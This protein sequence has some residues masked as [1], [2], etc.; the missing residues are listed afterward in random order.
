M[1][2][3]KSNKKKTPE[4]KIKPGGYKT[5][6][7]KSSDYL[8]HVFQTKLNK[9]WLDGTFDTLISK[10]ALEDID[11]YVGNKSGKHSKKDDVFFNT[12]RDNVQLE[13]GIVSDSRI[14]FDDVAQAINLYFDEYNYSKAYSTQSYVYNPPI[15]KDKFLNYSSYYWVPNLPVYESDNTNNTAT[16]NTDVITDINGK[17]THTFVD[18]N[19]TFELQDGMRIQLDAGYG[20]LN[21]KIYLVTGV[22]RAIN[23]RLYT[24]Y[25]SVLRDG[26]TYNQYYP[27]WTDESKYSNHTQGYWDAIDPIRWTYRLNGNPDTRSTTNNPLN[28]ITD[29][30]TDLANTAT[31]TA[32]AM[33]FYA[34]NDRKMYMSDGMIIQ[35]DDSWPGLP[36]GEEHKIYW[37]TVNSSGVTLTP[38]I[39]ASISGNTITQTIN[40][41]LTAAQQAK[42]ESYLS[43]SWDNDQVNWDTLYTATSVKDYHVIDR[44][45]KIATA[46][47]RSNFWVH[48]DTIFKIAEI[49][50]RVDGNLFV[51]KENQAKRPIIEFDGGIHMLYHQNDYAQ[52]W[53]GP[54]DFIIGL[55]SIAS[56]LQ[57]G[58]TY[59]AYNTNV[60]YKR[61]ST[62]GSD[63]V[64]RTLN[65]GDTFLCRFALSD[66]QANTDSLRTRF[67]RNDLYTDANQYTQIGQVKKKVNQPPLYILYDET[68]TRLDDSNKYPSS[69]FAGNKIFNYKIGTGTTVDPEVDLVL[70][71]KD[72]GPKADYV[73]ENA[74]YKEKYTHSLVT[75]DGGLVDTDTIKGYY[76]YK[77]YGKTKHGYTASAV[78]CG[79][80][81]SIKHIVKD[82]SQAQTIDIGYNAWRSS[83]EFYVYR[84]GVANSF[85][86][87]EGYNN[88]IINDK[89]RLR[90]ELVVKGGETYEFHDLIGNL[91]FYSDY[92][93]TV[94]TTGITTSGNTTTVVMPSSGVLYY[95]YSASNKG[96]ITILDNDDY[97]YHDLY[98]DGKRIRQNQYTINA[99]SIVVPASLVSTDSII[100]IDYMDSDSNNEATVYSIPD[101]HK[102]NAQN[103]VLEEFTI[104]ETFDHWEDIIYKTP[105]LTGQSFGIN[106]RHAKVKLDNT[107]GTIFMYDDISIMHDYTY[108]NTALDVREAL[109]TQGREFFGFRRRFKNQVLRL[110]KTNTY[111]SV[112]HIVRDAIKA[113]TSTRRG[114]DLHAKSNMVYWNDDRE[115]KQELTS[116]QTVIYVNE[117]V[118]ADYNSMDHCYVYLSEND[119]SNSYYERLLIKDVDYTIKGSTITLATAAT[120]V[121]ANDPA[122]V[123]L[124]FIDRNEKSYIPASMVKLGLEFATPVQIEGNRILFHDGDYHTWDN[125]KELYNPNDIDFDVVSACLY[126]LEKRIWAG[127]VNQDNTRSANTWLPTPFAD[128]WYDKNLLDNYTEQLYVDYAAKEGFKVYNNSGFYNASDSSTW[129]YSTITH[130]G[131]NVP[132]HWVGAYTYIFGTATPHLTPWHM[133]GF[134]LKPS[135]WDTHYSWTDATKRATLIDSLTKGIVTIPTANVVKTDLRFARWNWDWTNRC[136]V[137]TTGILADRHD[138]LGT[139]Q[140]IYAAQD[141]VFGDY[142]PYEYTWRRS[143]LGQSALVDAIVKL[144]PAKAWTEFF[145]PGLYVENGDT[146]TAKL[147]NKYTRKAITPNDIVYDGDAYGKKVSRIKVKNSTTG[148]GSNSILDLYSMDDV[149]RGVIKLDIDSTG[150]IKHA[151]LT[152]GAVGY[153]DIPIWDITNAGTG[154]NLDALVDFEFIMTDNYYDGNGIN[155]AIRN[156]YLRNFKEDT[157]S[158]QFNKV[159][160]NLLQKVGGFTSENLIDFYTESGAKGKYK[161]NVNDY[162]V[163]LYNGPPRTLYNACNI[164]I[165]R[166]SGGYKVNGISSNKQKFYM[167]EPLKKGSNFITIELP[168]TGSVKRYNDYDYSTLSSVEFGSVFAKIQD[169]YEFVRGYHHYLEYNGVETDYDGDTM[170]IDAAVFA[171]GAQLGEEEVLDIGSSVAYVGKEGRVVSFGSLPGGINT[172]LDSDGNVIKDKELVLDRYQQELSVTIEK[173]SAKEIGSITFAEVDFEHIVQFDNTTQFNDTLFNDV[174]NQRHYRLKARGQ[175]TKDWTGNTRA[176]GYLVFENKIV[177]NFD[178]SVQTIADLYSYNVENVNDAYTKAENLTIGNSNKDWITESL[179]DDQ[180]FAK[181]YQGMIKNKGITDSIEPFNRSSML[182]DGTSV[183]SVIEEWMFRHSYYGDTTNVDAP[184]IKLSDDLIDNNIE[185]IDFADS[186]IEFVN[187]SSVTFNTEVLSQYNN[188]SYKLKS[189]GE[190]I[191]ETENDSNIVPTLKDMKVIY[192]STKDYANIETWIGTKSYKRGDLVRHKGY[193]YKCNVNAIGFNT[194]AAQLTFTGTVPS[195]TFTYASASVPNPASATIDGVAVWFDEQDTVFNNIVATGNVTAPSVPSG[196]TLTVDG[197]TLTL[198]NVVLVQVIDT[199]AAENGNP[200]FTCMLSSVS[201][202]VIADNTGENLVINGATIP[203]VNATYPAGTALS[204]SDVANI[205]SSTSDTNL[206]AYVTPG[207]GNIVIRYNAQGNIN[208]NLVLGNGTANND[209]NI[210]AGTYT[211]SIINVNQAQNMDV[212]TLASKINSNGNKPAD[213]TA[214]VSTNRLVITKAPT[215]STTANTILQLSGTAATIAGLPSSTAVTSSQ[216]SKVQ[217]VQDARDS[218]NAAAITGVTA[219]VDSNNRLVISSTNAQLDLGSATNEMNSNA[220]MASG[221]QYATNTVV[222][223]TFDVNDWTDVSDEDEALFKIQVVD[224]ANADNVDNSIAGNTAFINFGAGPVSTN[225]SVPSVFNGWNLFQVQNLNWYSEITDDQGNVTQDCSICAGTATQDGNDACININTSH[226]LE[227][228]DYIMIVNST[229]IPSADGIHKVTKLG[230]A[231]EPKKFY[232][233]LFIEQCGQA[234]Q[235]Y[236]LR[237]CRFNDYNDI[238]K[239]NYNNRY[240]WKSGDIAWSNYHTGNSSNAPDRKTYV[241]KHNGTEFVIDTTRTVGT[242]AI[243]NAFDRTTTAFG[244]TVLYDGKNKQT[245]LQLE[246]FDPLNRQIPGVAAMQ[247]NFTT[248]VDKA[249]Y[250]HST[251]INEPVLTNVIDSWGEAERGLVWWDITNAIYFDYTQGTDDYKKNYWGRLIPGASIDVYEWTKS[252]VPPEEFE[253]ITNPQVVTGATFTSNPEFSTSVQ[254][255]SAGTD[256]EM[257]GEIANGIPYSVIDSTSGEKIYY[258]SQ[259]EEYNSKTGNY[260]KVYYFWVKNKTSY[261]AKPN[262]TLSVAGIANIIT[263]PTAFGISWAAATDAQKMIIANVQFATNKD[264]V[265]QINKILPKSSHN[266]WTV[267]QEGHGLIP[268]Y[269]YR[270]LSD[271]LVGR[272]KT[273]GVS[274]PNKNLHEF[275]RYGD[276]RELGQS[277]YKD[278]NNARCE[279]IDCLNRILKNINLVQ[280]LDGKWDRTIGGAKE[281]IDID[282]EYTSTTAWAP[283]TAYAIGDIVKFNK[284]IYKARIAHTSGTSSYNAFNTNQIWTRYASIVDLTAMWDYTDF[285]SKDRLTNELPTLTINRAGELDNVDITKHKIVEIRMV[286]TDGFDRTEIKKWNGS[287]WVLVE[288]RNATIKLADWLCSSSRIDK[289]DINPWDTLAWDGNLMIFW[290]YIVEAM[291]KDILIEQ[292]IDKFNH[293]FF[294]MVKYA[295]STQKQV[296]WVHKTTYVQLD[297]T[298]KVSDK[299]NK[300]RKGTINTLLGYIQTVKPFHTKIRNIIDRNTVKDEATVSITDSYKFDTT[301]KFEQTLANYFGE[302]DILTSGFDSVANEEEYE[303]HAF[304]DSTTPTNDLDGGAFINPEYHNWTVDN[305]NRNMLAQLDTAED[306]T[307]TVITNTSGS[308]VDANTR[309]F[310]YRQDGKLNQHI[311]VL[312]VASSTTITA[313]VSNDVTEIPLTS[314]A[315]FSATGGFAYINGEVLEYSGISGTN[316]IGVKRGYASQKNHTSG[317]T[318]VDITNANVFTGT[319]G[320]AVNAS[321]EY[322]DSNMINDIAY[323]SGTSEWEATTVLQGTGALPA[324]MQAGTQGIDF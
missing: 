79:A 129:N 198:T 249:T 106:D 201:N 20:S 127:I 272:Q 45:D 67:V 287:E 238:L 309:T 28:I 112:K 5:A 192:D 263:N 15:D 83:R 10:G 199:T 282:T 11:G 71:Y 72:I 58:A 147:V 80:K 306:L 162:N 210:I 38:I 290:N 136:P 33:F 285:V 177:E 302:G 216:V 245:S 66:T 295:L 75:A 81:E 144:N 317:D 14:T 60:I 8:P 250:T 135:W 222:A 225:T 108:A 303:G 104:S 76:A 52:D 299:I 280:D 26:K 70:S 278:I 132:G 107:G 259:G 194:Q 48:R 74:I 89:K 195:P 301:I 251:D 77:C 269:W 247:I 155:R 318:I 65:Q 7:L 276:D 34:N 217:T 184:E 172:I 113:I 165:E 111:S 16:Y 220:G 102:H 223:N 2:E 190:V 229:S 233:D 174:T 292:H 19:N 124:Q 227:V 50:P 152:E 82:G 226:N 121:T 63:P 55:P 39:Q 322:V 173:N 314:T 153:N 146:D 310:V 320:D 103:K 6:N 94:T 140:A 149:R 166:V 3:Y 183:A 316:L 243:N 197:N 241:Y 12:K 261:A 319:I 64:V 54:V 73:F 167:Y 123:T 151:T 209:L 157:V 1:S 211:P 118:N 291:R 139:P 254:T 258:Y 288:K 205:I 96:K 242:V 145:Q 186:N 234:P 68:D 266:S 289:W 13:P 138:V 128:T 29:Y 279:A 296:D 308:T 78:Q 41:G 265:L 53:A 150:V 230:E 171:V 315:N 91:T 25:I 44:S 101:V 298:T 221:I 32:P 212:N 305:G 214:S 175:R 267:L 283:N 224:D 277:W 193:L 236:V 204:K 311:D 47:S 143:S 215:S 61:D 281:F 141:F 154:S 176:P 62:Q 110:Y 133:L 59:I 93:G 130:N 313:D 237:N 120:A 46:W 160:T 27:V 213:I 170:A 56:Q 202:P 207:T 262:R 148:W 208:T 312:E 324:R 181:F 268:E 231:N 228:G 88:G 323:N 257:F 99:T 232:I 125:T 161:V 191:N 30:N 100:D 185:V 98:I 37:A 35:L 286:D 180:T 21:K 187:G 51:N 274:F 270:G 182:N 117:S 189:A 304:T 115:F 22:G 69:T 9:K 275:N 23:L 271:N 200:F 219:S 158:T 178:S 163:H 84:H 85:T 253:T 40:S 206:S 273:S 264:T 126:D 256:V 137:T 248:F 17:P 90:P 169:L 252:T 260:E 168:T 203:L 92:A 188:R 246:V 164:T 97:L 86:A 255:Q 95:G 239:V 105:G 196:S 284:K 179:L 156:N 142:G 87:S 297:V 116:T 131:K 36:A 244:N 159:D 43:R 49:V 307:I 24:D 119:G 122:F 4:N 300:Y 109:A 134:S 114:T 18:D 218:I 31:N 57:D 321:N 294:C 42:A 235:I 240:N 293:F